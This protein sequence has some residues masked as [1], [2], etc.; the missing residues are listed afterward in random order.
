MNLKYSQVI[1][2]AYRTRKIMGL[3]MECH[4][5]VTWRRAL[6]KS[7]LRDAGTRDKGRQVAEQA[8]NNSSKLS[9]YLLYFMG[10]GGG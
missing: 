2:Q 1:P 7:T 3:G 10:H 6:V 4:A 5:Q 9:N 8:C